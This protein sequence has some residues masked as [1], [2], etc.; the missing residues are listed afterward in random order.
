MKSNNCHILPLIDIE[1]YGGD[2]TP[3]IVAMKKPSGADIDASDLEDASFKLSLTPFKAFNGLGEYA[4]TIEPVLEIEG[5]QS[6]DPV[7][8]AMSAVFSFAQSDTISLRGKYIYQID[9]YIDGEEDGERRIGQGA[10]LIKGNIN[11]VDTS[12]PESV[13]S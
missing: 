9:V 1:R 6:V 4:G 10:M 8:G 11:I 7:T 3:I 12:D 13:G 2:T 5:V